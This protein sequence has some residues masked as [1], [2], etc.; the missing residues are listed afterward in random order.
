MELKRRITCQCCGGELHKIS[1]SEWKCDYCSV[2]YD[3]VSVEKHVKTM[4]QL[5][6]DAKLEI[7]SNLR[8]N[9]YDAVNSRF[10]SDKRVHECCAELKKYLPDD[11]YANFYE[12]AIGADDVEISKYIMAIDPV[13]DY[14]AVG[15]VVNFLIKSLQ[16]GFL[17]ALNDLV[18]RA[19]KS[20]DL[21]KFEKYSTMIS[22]EAEKVEC[23]VYE[24]NVPRDV[25]VAYSSKDMPK[26]IEL[27]DFLEYQ[28][29]TCFVAARNLRHGRGAVE[30]YN[31]ALEDAM[32]NCKTFVFV[33]SGNSRNFSCDAVRIE[34][35]FI[36]SLDMSKAP[37]EYHDHYI[38]IPEKYKKFRVEYK[39]DRSR[40]D[41]PLVKEF[42]DGYEWALSKNEVSHRIQNY[43]TTGPAPTFEEEE[44]L[45][46]EEAERARE[47]ERRREEEERRR[48]EERKAREE[49]ERRRAEERRRKEAEAREREEE[50]ARRKAKRQERMKKYPTKFIAL[51]SITLAAIIAAVICFIFIK[52][53]RAWVIS[54]IVA[55]VYIDFWNM[56]RA[57]KPD[58]NFVPFYTFT[59]IGLA[60]ACIPLFCFNETTRIYAAGFALAV[61][62]SS[63]RLLEK[64]WRF[65]KTEFEYRFRTR[66]FYFQHGYFE[67]QL[68][69]YSI[70]I[71]GILFAIGLGCILGGF[72]GYL[73]AGC[74]IAL[75]FL[76]FTFL[77][78]KLYFDGDT[79]T[80]FIVLDVIFAVASFLSLS[81][82]FS[83]NASLLSVCMSGATV[84]SGIILWTSDSTRDYL[85]YEW[86][87]GAIA[88]LISVPFL[89]V[90]CL[91]L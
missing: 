3:D 72:V 69:I 46:R 40:N 60:V 63:A 33:S 32:R 51:R 70:L 21:E 80:A 52:E 37:A 17:L 82:S 76:S 74:G 91:Y 58:F 18:E 22:S 64:C 16:P 14:A 83:V 13:E 90:T 6:D 54:A 88:L 5:L 66:T 45:R 26:V 59:N 7:I 34:I 84:L 44:R 47:E 24:T 81:F 62:A 31:K 89:V 4:E 53:S 2:V 30:N 36:K 38:K 35:P 65:K 9:L 61:L 42:F 78:T 28:G 79:R 25:F 67:Y 39:I 56:I 12:A 8:K 55:G 41:N 68:N 1:D 87:I 15:S 11:F 85:E 86:I 10:V 71:G 77:S 27:V 29:L 43:I 75:S 50:K 20:R 49:E 57:K 19:Y 48:A 23:G 73:V